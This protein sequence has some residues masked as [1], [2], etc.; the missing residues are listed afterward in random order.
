MNAR[1]TLEEEK[2]L[3]K[4][5]KNGTSLE[6][7]SKEFGRSENAL[8]LRIKKIIYDT[9]AEKKSIDSIAKSLKIT[10]DKTKQY[11]YSYK[12]MLEK[13][14]KKTIDLIENGDK[15]NKKDSKKDRKTNRVDLKTNRVDLKTNK[16]DLKTNKV[17]LK[18]NKPSYIDIDK[19]K[20]QNEHMT[21]ILKH[22]ELKKEIKKL[23]S[24]GK[25]DKKLKLTLTQLFEKK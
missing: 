23:L 13:N 19:I 15:S 21:I 9:V 11:F 25:I 2:K 22:I 17:D 4:S 20:K 3:I 6:I 24:D 16:V 14:G 18:T 7:M 8:E 5:V 10:E 12:D 1:W